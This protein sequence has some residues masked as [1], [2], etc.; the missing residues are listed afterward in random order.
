MRVKSEGDSNC[1]CDP[2]AY[3]LNNRS[4]MLLLIAMLTVSLVISISAPTALAASAWWHVTSASTPS[5]LPPGGEGEIVVG[6]S[7]IGDAP[8]NGGTSP[9]VISDRLPAGLTAISISSTTG[10]FSRNF[11]GE[12][13]LE[14]L[15]CRF[16]G[17]YFAFEH[18]EMRIRVS[19]S[20]AATSE[21]QASVA[22]GGG[23]GAS[24]S[25]LV[26]ISSDP[27]PFGVQS[28]E[29]TPENEGGSV[30]TLAD[31]HPF[32]L[33]TTFDINQ[34]LRNGLAETA[35]F[36]KDLH[37][38]LPCLLYTSPSPRDRTRSRMPSSA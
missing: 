25:K 35:V 13:S 6:A 2:Q 34:R 22:G 4:A 27:T 9:I 37:F 23:T 18:L 5:N 36:P 8:V 24:V 7:D 20:T 10:L 26:N 12:C 29:L 28:F 30:D 14:T 11:E 16:S 1:L 19:I 38:N 33:T 3:A 17:E 21:N 15:S 31:S 32:Q